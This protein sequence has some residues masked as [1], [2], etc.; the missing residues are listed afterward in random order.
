MEVSMQTCLKIFGGRYEKSESR[1]SIGVHDESTTY[2]SHFTSFFLFFFFGAGGGNV[3]A[4]GLVR[5]WMDA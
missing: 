5:G 2:C 4:A 1:S 3:M